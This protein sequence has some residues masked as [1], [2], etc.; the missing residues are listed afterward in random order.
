MLQVSTGEYSCKTAV[1]DIKSLKM[2]WFQQLK[3]NKIH[4]FSELVVRVVI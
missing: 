3:L 2:H 4:D 1:T